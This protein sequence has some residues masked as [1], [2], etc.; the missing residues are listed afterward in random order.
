MN[1]KLQGII[2]RKC[3]LERNWSQTTLCTGICAVSYLSKIEQGRVTGTPEVLSLLLRRL[4]IDWR[5]E[6]AFRKRASA[7]FEGWYERLFSGED[8]DDMKQAMEDHRA[9]YHDSPFFLDWLLLSWLAN[10]EPPEE[11]EEYVPA[12]NQ[13]QQTLYLYLTEQFQELLRVADQSYYLL[14]V[15]RHFLDQG[16]YGNAVD[17]LQKG[18]EMAAREGSLPIQMLCCGSLGN[19]HSCLNQLEQTRKY[20][21]AASRMARILGS[22]TDMLIINY[23]LAATEMQMGMT[24][25]AL[26]HLLAHPWNEALYYH[27]VA[28]CYEVLGQREEALAALDKALVTPLNGMPGPPELHHAVFEQA[29]QVLR[30]RVTDPNFLKNPE[31]GNLLISCVERLQQFFP[32]TFV[33]FHARWLEEWYMAN[34]QHQKAHNLIRK[35]F[36][37][38]PV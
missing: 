30:L 2:I 5:E 1:Q 24:E 26:E 25:E 19:C 7:W 29:C 11:P 22:L 4:G 31:Y 8:T 38:N 32:I 18:M 37:D 16:H 27:K 23:N 13:R 12:M 10:D 34:R 33:R 15:G 17:C 9:E 3:R 36:L 20:Y 35:I 6:P 21:T 14:A 28:A